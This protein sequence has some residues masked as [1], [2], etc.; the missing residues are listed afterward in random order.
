M[1]VPVVLG[2]ASLATGLGSMIFGG[3]K[4]RKARR[5]QEQ[6]VR[7]QQL[8]DK[9]FFNKEYY[10]PYVQSEE[11]Q[12]TLAA[13][14]EAI[15][16]RNK[17]VAQSQAISGGSDEA[18]VA[19]QGKTERS[20]ADLMR[21]IASQGTRYKTGVREGFQRAQRGTRGALSGMAQQEVK[22]GQNLS[23]SGAG[24]VS[25]SLKSLGSLWGK[26]EEK[27]EVANVEE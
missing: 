14:R 7:E 9:A 15:K 24:M 13:M 21:N 1:A 27:P 5:R 19:A 16:E 10:T 26:K 22:S 6:L 3:A 11:A 8:E 17:Q 18:K 4:A 12:N 23:A 2:V 25:E 20:Y